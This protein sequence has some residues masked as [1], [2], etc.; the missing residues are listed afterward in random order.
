MNLRHRLHPDRLGTLW[1]IGL[2]LLVAATGCSNERR[3]AKGKPLRSMGS[4]AVLDAYEDAALQWDWVSMKVDV[5]LS[6]QTGLQMPSDSLPDALRQSFK[7]TVRIARDSAVWASISPAL[8]IEVA[9][10]LIRPDSVFLV[11]KIP[12][13]AFYAAEPLA[14]L[15][16]WTGVDLGFGDLQDLLTGRPLGIEEDKDR[17]LSRIDG[18]QYLLVSRYKRPVRRLVGVDD[19]ELGPSD[20]VRIQV[21]DRRY[22]RVRNHSDGDD[23]LIQRH[24]FN[25]LTFDPER[26]VFDD[27]YEQRFIHIHRRAFSDPGGGRMPMEMEIEFRSPQTTLGLELDIQRVRVDSPAEL[28][29]EIPDGTPR[30]TI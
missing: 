24:W 28:P 8:G 19:R 20:T 10:L 17:F 6:G 23:L 1:P 11:S 3:L 21:P 15:Q 2:L 18:Q 29:F 30:K 14:G 5:T 25:G 22:E 13:N 16:R 7:A 26:D 27:L 12:G 9:R 4:A